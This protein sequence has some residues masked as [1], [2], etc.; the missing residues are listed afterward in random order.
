MSQ[1]LQALLEK[2]MGH[3]G[4]VVPA[5]DRRLSKLTST[6][7]FQKIWQIPLETMTLEAEFITAPFHHKGLNPCLIVLS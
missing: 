6:V 1:S 5:S 4:N 2:M 3:P 7:T